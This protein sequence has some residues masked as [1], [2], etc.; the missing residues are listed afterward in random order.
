MIMNIK[1]NI[2]VD[3]LQHIVGTEQCFDV[4]E[5]LLETGPTLDIDIPE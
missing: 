3:Y 4:V 2:K 1:M 5:I